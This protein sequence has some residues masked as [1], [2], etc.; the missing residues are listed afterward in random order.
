[1]RQISIEKVTLNIGVGEPGEKLEKAKRLLERISSRKA[2]QTLAKRRVPTW[3][4]R[5]GLPIG[6]KV[7]LRGKH[8]EEI[9]KKLFLAI[10]NKVKR[11]SFDQE[12]NLSFGIEEYIQIP[13]M[14]Y[15]PDIGMFGLDVCITLKRPGFRIKRRRV[16]A[17]VPSR[18]RI[19]P[20]EAIEFF[21]QK[22][23]V[24]IG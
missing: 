15:D 22:F 8:A 6:V 10:E 21:R 24:E 2:V 4:I 17:R 11:E 19:T 9:L 1:M 23:G 5:P 13:G 16:P 3:G 14:R 18:H 20:E 12:G 7:T